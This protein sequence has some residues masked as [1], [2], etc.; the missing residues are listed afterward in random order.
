MYL[1]DIYNSSLPLPLSPP[2]PHP[3]QQSEP[4]VFNPFL[5]GLKSDFVGTRYSAFWSHVTS[6]GVTL[7]SSV[8]CGVS[9]VTPEQAK[10]VSPVMTHLILN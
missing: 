3:L 5:R 7:V 9:D 8:E 4:T 6:E 2:P 10:Q 1:I